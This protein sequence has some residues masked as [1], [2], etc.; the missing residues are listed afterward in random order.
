MAKRKD[1]KTEKSRARAGPASSGPQLLYGV[2]PVLH[3]L[4]NPRR[5]VH[6][7]LATP[8]AGRR[9]GVTLARLR[10][11]VPVTT[12]ERRDIDAVL[13]PG[14][15]HQGLAAECAPLSEPAL[16]SLLAGAPENAVIVALDQVTDPQNL[17]AVLRVAA[18]FAATAV[19]ITERHAPHA[20][21]ALAKAAAG[22]LEHVPMVREVNLARTLRKLQDAGFW[23]VGLD[24]EA[25]RTLAEHAPAGRTVLV[26]GAEGAGLRRLTRETCDALVRIPI[27]DAV[28]SLNVATATAVA[29]YELRRAGTE[30]G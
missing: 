9:H 5:T 27:S 18:A 23:C 15:V 11:D 3:A 16:D 1:R 21:G 14:A 17:G 12:V 8:E 28:E 20:T 10:P 24:G 4:A 29:L 13:P 6:R 25:P 22:A 7:L 26:L 19:V 30:T 2:H